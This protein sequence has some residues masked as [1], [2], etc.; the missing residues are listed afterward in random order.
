MKETIRASITICDICACIRGNALISL[1]LVGATE[2][3]T[4]HADILL[5]AHLF[6][7]VGAAS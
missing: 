7:P 4:F 6:S 3:G 1:N 5:K 2:N